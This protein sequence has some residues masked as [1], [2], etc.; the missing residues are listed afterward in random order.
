M[1]GSDPDPTTRK[2][3]H[4]LAVKAEMSAVLKGLQDAVA[5]SPLCPLLNP[6]VWSLQNPQ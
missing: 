5:D 1:P 4:V 2:Q 3:Y 6:E